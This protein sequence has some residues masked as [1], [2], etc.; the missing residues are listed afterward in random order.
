[1]FAVLDVAAF[2]GSVWLNHLCESLS[3]IIIVYA[4]G[5]E[6]RSLNITCC[7]LLAAFS[8][9]ADFQILQD[10]DRVYITMHY[11]FIHT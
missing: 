4:R 6:I 1:M 7:Q 11:T 10:L 9:A 8:V 3:R 2:A 5:L